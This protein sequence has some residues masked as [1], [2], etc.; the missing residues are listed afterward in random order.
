MNLGAMLHLVGKLKEAEEEYLSAWTL[1]THDIQY[2]RTTN[3]GS[4][5]EQ[6]ASLNSIKVNLIRLHNIMKRKG[7]PIQKVAEV[8]N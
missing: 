4:H 7:M 5:N 6:I 2:K 8:D 1:S 3:N